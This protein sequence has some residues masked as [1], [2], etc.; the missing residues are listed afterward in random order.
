M[1]QHHIHPSWGLSPTLDFFDVSKS[2]IN[3]L[4][5]NEESNYKFLQVAPADCRHTAAAIAKFSTKMKQRTHIEGLNITVWEQEPICI[6]RHSLLLLIL[7][8]DGLTMREKR[9]LF[10]DVFSNVRVRVRTSEYVSSA[11][12]FLEEILYGYSN[13]RG[14]QENEIFGPKLK[15]RLEYLFDFSKL[16]V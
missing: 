3:N 6:A 7:F 1:D 5:L 14:R 10:L 12:L 11:G 8:D 9:E 4:N 2:T 13:T 15:R 16:K